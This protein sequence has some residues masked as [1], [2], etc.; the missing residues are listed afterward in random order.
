[1]TAVTMTTGGF[2][3]SPLASLRQVGVIARRNLLHVWSDPQQLV[4]MTVQPLMFLL[5]FVYVFGG[6]IAGS[7]RAYM[8]FVLPGLVVQGVTFWAM[9]TAVGLNTDFQRGLVD[10]FRSLPIAR[11]AVVAGRITADLVRTG[12]GAVITVA[13]A[14]AFGFRL[15]TGVARAAGALG[16]ILAWG[17][18]L[19]WLMAY[20]GVS[21][22]S[23]EAVQTAAFLI[24]MPLGFASSI[25]APVSSMPGWLQA[26]VRVNPVTVVTGAVRGLMLG[27]PVARPVLESAAWLTGITVV[28]WALTLRRYRARV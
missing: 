13:V 10:R 1:M 8:Q 3:A 26:F 24:V 4:G 12:W 11:S 16:M 2:A 22:R 23:A 7:S 15:H 25:F 27:G 6:A 5:L 17:F 19:S 14:A 20:L 28:C 9:Q 18:A 21:L